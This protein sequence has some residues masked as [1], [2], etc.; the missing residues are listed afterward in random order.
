MS[1]QAADKWNR[2]TPVPLQVI[3]YVDQGVREKLPAGTEVLGISRSGASYWARTAKIDATNE[4]GEETPF[5]IKV[6]I[7]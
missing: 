1:L 7:V 3:Q 4:A 6:M 5:F 2:E